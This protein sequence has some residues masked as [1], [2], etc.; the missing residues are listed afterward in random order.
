MT[1]E[2]ALQIVQWGRAHELSNEE[3][4][5]EISI[6]LAESGAGYELDGETDE[7]WDAVEAEIYEGPDNR[8]AGVPNE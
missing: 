5:Q 4:R 1:I 8:F 2:R 6:E 3:I 7:L